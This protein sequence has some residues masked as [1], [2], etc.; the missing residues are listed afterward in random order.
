MGERR[1]SRARRLGHGVAAP[2]AALALAAGLSTAHAAQA[3]DT[4]TGMLSDGT[5]GA[6]HAAVA[7]AEGLT[8]RQCVFECVKA[9]A[10]YVL[11]D[12]DGAARPIANQDAPGLP[13]HSGRRVR[14]TGELDGDAIVVAAIEAAPAEPSDDDGR[15]RSGRVRRP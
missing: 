4:W 10:R 1:G 6:D 3:Q 9:L 13:F 2:F 11:V 14:V 7:S 5:C 8:D 12:D 15:Q